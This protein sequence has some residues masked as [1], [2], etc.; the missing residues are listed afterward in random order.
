MFKELF[1]M[2]ARGA[3]SLLLSADEANGL[4]TVVVVPKTSDNGKEV[5]ALA[6]PLKLTATPEELDAGFVQ[7]VASYA[8]A[9][10]SLDEQV[11][12]TNEVLEAAKAASVKK[13]ADALSKAGAKAA[14]KGAHKPMAASSEPVESDGDGDASGGDEDAQAAPSGESNKP[15]PASGT[16]VPDLFGA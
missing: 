4:M 3:F 11:A 12:A 6:V 1:P 2:A 10:T 14:P 15:A 9:R 16:T 7:A 8:T 13:G 5:P